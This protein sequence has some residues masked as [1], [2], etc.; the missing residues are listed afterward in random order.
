LVNPWICLAHLRILC[1]R[2]EKKAKPVK[3]RLVKRLLALL[4]SSLLFF[5]PDG[6]LLEMEKLWTNEFI[7]PTIWESFMTNQ[8]KQWGDGNLLVMQLGLTRFLQTYA[9]ALQATVMLTVDVSF[10]TINGVVVN[11]L[12]ASPNPNPNKEIVFTSPV[13]IAITLSIT[14]S[15]ASIVT[16]MLLVRYNSSKVREPPTNTVSE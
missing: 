8:L 16:G 9:I 11:N 15:I 13:L 7:T 3:L 6:Y 1:L 4:V 12:N 5:T 2:R 14:T 10:L